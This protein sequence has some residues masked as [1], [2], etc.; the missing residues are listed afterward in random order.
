VLLNA[1]NESLQSPAQIDAPSTKD[2]LVEVLSMPGIH[3]ESRVNVR[4][5]EH[6]VEQPKARQGS[7][8]CAILEHR[9]GRATFTVENN[10]RRMHRRQPAAFP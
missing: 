3:G 10:M 4:V 9:V 2:E 5:H 1:V 6:V 7:V 8:P